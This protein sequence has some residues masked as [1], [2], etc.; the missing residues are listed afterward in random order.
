MKRCRARCASIV[1]VKKKNLT[2][3]RVFVKLHFDW[4]ERNDRRTKTGFSNAL[5]GAGHEIVKVGHNSG[6]FPVEIEHRES[7]RKLYQAVGSF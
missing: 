1:V 6:E 3:R 4:R 5:A 7:V 2:K